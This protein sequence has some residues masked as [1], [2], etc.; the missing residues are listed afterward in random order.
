MAIL[1]ID[2]GGTRI[3]SGIV[4]GD[5]KI[6][7]VDQLKAIPDESIEKNLERISAHA[8]HAFG[9]YTSTLSAIGIAVPSIVDSNTNRVV[10]RY[11]KYADAVEFGFN[12]W[13]EQEWGLPLALENDARAALIG[14]WQYGSGRGYDDLALLTLGTGI[15]SAVLASGKLYKGKHLLAGSM[16]GH[17]SINLHG[18]ACNCGFFGCLEREA[19]TWALPAKLKDHALYPSSSLSRIEH[20]EFIH[21]FEE[22]K[23]GDALASIVLEECLKAWGVAAVNLVHAHDPERIIIGGG[24]MKQRDR[25]IP[26]LQNMVDRYAWLPPGTTTIVA[27][28]QVEYAGLLGMGWLAHSLNKVS[29]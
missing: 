10:S 8:R 27:A 29:P 26:Y 20:P 5:G 12:Q 16:T 19:S 14:E 15:G 9:E 1:V 2:F 4:E 7:T 22:E 28:E 3:K 23:K 21:L 13:A 6:V 11:V 18:D 25:I 17:I 24:I